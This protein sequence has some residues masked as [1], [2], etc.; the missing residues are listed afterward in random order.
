MQYQGRLG[1]NDVWCVG[2]Y[3][4][5]DYRK[6]YCPMAPAPQSLRQAEGGHF[7]HLL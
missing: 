1:D 3:R 6:R 2:G 7:E 5:E 4:S